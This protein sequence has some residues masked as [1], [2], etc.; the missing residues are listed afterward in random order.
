MRLESVR[1][2]ETKERIRDKKKGKKIQR[3]SETKQKKEG[4]TSFQ[5]A[6]NV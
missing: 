5:L 2:Q 4:L 1:E 6:A 3:E